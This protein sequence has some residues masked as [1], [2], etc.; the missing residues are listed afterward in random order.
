MLPDNRDHTYFQVTGANG[1]KALVEVEIHG[2]NDDIVAMDDLL[3]M[4]EGGTSARPRGG[5]SRGRTTRAP[6]LR[7][8]RPRSAGTWP[9]S[10]RP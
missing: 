10:P 2:L 5:P 3:S 4:V 6:P 9:S 1:Q 7:P 8:T